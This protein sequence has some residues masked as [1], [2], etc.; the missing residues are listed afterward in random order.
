MLREKNIAANRVMMQKIGLPVPSRRKFSRHVPNVLQPDESDED[1]SD[2]NQSTEEI[3]TPLADGEEVYL[4]HEKFEVFKAKYEKSNP[5]T[6]VHGITIQED[7]GRFFITKVMRNVIKW[8]DF[9]ADVMCEGAAILWKKSDIKRRNGV[10]VNIGTE[11]LH[12]TPR[13]ER[14]RKRQPE[15]W[16]K[17]EA[18][19]AKNSG[20]EFTR[21]RW[22][23]GK[24]YI[25][26]VKRKELK[27][28]C[29]CK[30]FKCYE[31]FTEE[32]R[33]KIFDDFYNAADKTI[34]SQQIA[35][36]VK[37]Q[38]KMRERKRNE[39]KIRTRTMSRQYHL[40]FKGE[41]IQCCSVMFLNTFAIDEKRVQ[42]VL[43]KK[44]LT[45]TPLTDRRGKHQSHKTKERERNCV[46]EH[47]M[48]FQVLES[49]YVRK[50][51]KYEYLPLG[52]S[53]AEM[54]R[55]YNE[56]RETKE[57]PKVTYNFY[58]TVFR[59]CFNLKFQMLKK[60]KCDTCEAYRNQEPETLTDVM[61]LDQQNH[62]KEKE[63]VKKIKKEC[64]EDGQ[65]DKKLVVAAFDLQ[66]VLLTPFG[67]T[68]SFYYSRR[69]TNHNFTIT[70]IVSMET[71]CYFWT[72][73]ECQKGSCEV[74]T[75]L[76]QFLKAKSE[77]G[78]TR[79][80]LFCDRCGGQNNNR[81][82]FVMLSFALNTLPIESI[83]L[84]YLVSGHSHSEND[85]A[86]SVIEQLAS[87]K[88]IYTP[89]E[90]EAVIKCA[91]KKHPC[92][93]TV[94]EHKDILDFKSTNAFPDYSLVLSDKTEEIM[95]KEQKEK[96]K[97]H[98]EE[99]G[100]PNRKVDK[101]FWS[102]IVSIKF[103]SDDPEKIL[104]KYSYEEDYRKA[105]FSATKKNLRTQHEP[106][107]RKYRQPC[108]INKQKKKDLLQLC[109]K[110]LIPSRHHRFYESLPVNQ[111]KDTNTQASLTNND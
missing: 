42:T 58:A 44:T 94:L 29:I 18:K 13:L 107:I 96:Q 71:S 10:D 35:A 17:N 6:A 33:K 99:I 64:K 89:A 101:V 53:I 59:E 88:T 90:W 72:E 14:K 1:N 55:M 56:W 111:G 106:C 83:T 25:S 22:K 91:F 43:S 31:V 12:P 3:E 37:E 93:L 102:E 34:Q 45:G 61:K 63:A 4:L 97:Q 84:T 36:L 38:K 54:H 20:K 32:I 50:E 23:D 19:K 11:A 81:M 68:S 104:F 21:K 82:I 75:S 79:F 27:P 51:S 2:A 30:R 41:A 47:I 39:A 60:D 85:N 5:G 28:P 7:E 26:T 103:H 73:A 9:D 70:D 110:Q 65:V 67:Q 109:Q 24:A 105:K 108:G 76:L 87:N 52:L 74:A 15:K 40:F 78:V 92:N 98:N 46:K 49:H 95:S 57:Y 69:L 8:K 66:K 48:Q 80:E 77:K 86:H 62:L 100:M 16:E